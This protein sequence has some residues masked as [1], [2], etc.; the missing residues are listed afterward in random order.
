VDTAAVVTAVLSDL[1]RAIAENAA[2]ITVD[3][4][5]PV[6]GDSAQIRQVFQN[7]VSNAI[8]YRSAAPPAIH[9]SGESHRGTVLI[10]VR[11]NGIGFRPEEA[12]TIFGML[13]RLHG[14][15]TP[16]TGMGLAITRKIIERHGGRIWAESKPGEGSTF[17][18][19]LPAGA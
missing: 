5:P 9:I 3:P 7:L 12:E 16:G 15:S 11:D 17:S 10:R 19:T 8:K 13:K 14:R 1:Q 6:Q 4:L 18:F 2:V